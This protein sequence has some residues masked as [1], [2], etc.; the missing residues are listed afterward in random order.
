MAN[1]VKTLRDNA[2]G[3]F[4]NL[5][6]VIWSENLETIGERALEGCERLGKFF[7]PTNFLPPTC[8]LIG[9]HAFK[10]TQ[11]LN[12][13]II[14]EHALVHPSAFNAS[15]VWDSSPYNEDDDDDPRQLVNWNKKHQHENYP[16]HEMFAKSQI[17]PKDVLHELCNNDDYLSSFSCNRLYKEKDRYGLTPMMDY[18]HRNPYVD[19]TKFDELKLVTASIAR[20]MRLDGF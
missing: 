20:M 18:L 15:M 3:M 19:E 5:E 2:F 12:M 14:P 13:I 1:T 17:N 16:I 9:P 11:F 10:N 7:G 4:T 6:E 8:R